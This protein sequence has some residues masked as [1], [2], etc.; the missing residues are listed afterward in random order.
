MEFSYFSDEVFMKQAL[1]QARLAYEAGEVPVGALIVCKN[2]IV[3]KA[4]NSVVQLND[5]T[6]HAEMMAISTAAEYLGSRYLSDCT[7][8][9]TLEPCPMCAGALF[10]SQI[11]KVVYAATDDKRGSGLFSPN[12][13]HPKTQLQSGFLAEEST[14]LLKSFFKERR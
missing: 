8:Y 7:L 5:P 2:T 6:A 3:A 9:V 12:L 4:Y 10:W 11:G 13:Y 1:Q 14:L